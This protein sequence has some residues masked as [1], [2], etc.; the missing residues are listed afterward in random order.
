[1]ISCLVKAAKPHSKGWTGD[2][3]SVVMVDTGFFN[4]PY[5]ADKNYQITV[6]AVIGNIADDEWGHGT[7]CAG[8]AA[9]V[10]D[11]GIGIAGVSW[12]CK[13]MLAQI[14]DA[15]SGYY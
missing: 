7:H 2:G 1:M 3:I 13:I 9:A 10:T 15:G 8:I 14:Y 12:N 11:N 4:H 6:N 5:Y